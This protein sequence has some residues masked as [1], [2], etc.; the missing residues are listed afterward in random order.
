MSEVDD[1]LKQLDHPLL[2][3]IHAMR[4]VIRANADI[5]EHIKWNAPSFVYAGDD[6]ITLNFSGNKLRVIF[7]CGAKKKE[8]PAQRMIAD[9]DQLLTWA[10]N[11]RAIYE[12]KSQVQYRQQE[13]AFSRL[14]SDWLNCFPNN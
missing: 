12:V 13:V 10:S 5:S 8:L 6:R 1:F 2:D 4:S 11:D 14:V 7:H 3:V 9:S